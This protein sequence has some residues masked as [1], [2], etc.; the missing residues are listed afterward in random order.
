MKRI[1]IDNSLIK[2]VKNFNDILFCD[3]RQSG[4]KPFILPRTGLK[5]L[6][7]TL[8]DTNQKR[9][10]IK[11]F[12]EYENL[13]N[14]KPSEFYQKKQEFDNIYIINGIKGSI[15][16]NF[17]KMVVE[18]LRYDSYRNSQYPNIINKLRWNLKACFYC[19]Y[20][21]TLTLTRA[22]K[23]KTFYDLDH[24][25]PKSIYPFLATSF[26][27]FIPSCATCNRSKS[28]K[29]IN[30]LNPFYEI[31]E[32]NILLNT[33]FEITNVSKVNF[34]TKN[35]ID[36]IS[37][38]VADKINNVDKKEFDKIVDLELLYNSQKHIAAE[39]LWKKRIYTKSYI[40][41]IKTTFSKLNLKKHDINR[42]LWG[43]DLND[44]TVNRE[45]LAKFKF[46]LINDI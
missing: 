6:Y 5:K 38:V 31:G 46:D 14:L 2:T 26:F 44:E 1:E 24:I 18:A 8:N 34:Y 28:T 4:N 23:Y 42:I 20:V 19:N 17:G 40:N 35:E 36:K 13:L 11:L 12:R 25:Y 30:E 37:I 7:K 10:I 41:T 43:I 21:G 27:N 39:I 32:K 33:V 22:K 29:I 3:R 15:S 16:T 45:P 9:Y